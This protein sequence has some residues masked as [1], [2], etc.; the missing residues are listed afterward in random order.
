MEFNPWKRKGI[1]VLIGSHHSIWESPSDIRLKQTR[2]SGIY[3][4]L[5][6]IAQ[7][8]SLM[9]AYATKNQTI[10]C[11]KLPLNSGV[12]VQGCDAYL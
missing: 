12:S 11:L 2:D 8:L 7:V 5:D 4:R 1:P 10:N 3:N 6:E 9:L